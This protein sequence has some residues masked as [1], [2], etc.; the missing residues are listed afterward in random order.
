MA[1]RRAT[2]GPVIL[3][4]LASAALAAVAGNKPWF[5]P[6]LPEDLAGAEAIVARPEVATLQES[7]LAGALALVVLAGW[8]VVLATRGRFRRA[9]AG[10]SALAG[11]AF[12]VTVVSA[13]WTMQ[14]PLADE[15]A[16]LT[17]ADEVRTGMTWGW[18]AALVAGALVLLTTV[19]AARLVPTW[20]EMGARYDAPT[21]AGRAGDVG[22]DQPSED[23][24]DIWKALD[25]GRDPTA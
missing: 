15:V 9:V 24:L 7:P 6:S 16:R 2:F 25:E 11:A 21:G 20:P 19:V 10:L 12:A 8:G 4:G 13:P 5:D 22:T 18:W 23:N 14:E 1:D 17:G 3:L